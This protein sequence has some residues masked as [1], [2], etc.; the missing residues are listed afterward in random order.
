[1]VSAAY[2]P[3]DHE[4]VVY[5]P[6]ELPPPPEA[7]GSIE[8]QALSVE[9]PA[10]VD[11][12]EDLP[13]LLW[14]PTDN[15]AIVQ[16][17]HSS[18][19]HN[20]LEVVVSSAPDPLTSS[21]ES[22][23]EDAVTGEAEPDVP[24][25]VPLAFGAGPLARYDSGAGSTFVELPGD[26][27]ALPSNVVYPED[28][29]IAPVEQPVYIAVPNAVL[30]APIAE[31]EDV[32][33]NVVFD[34][35]QASP[36]LATLGFHRVQQAY[37]SWLVNMSHS[38]SLYQGI[39][40]HNY[41]MTH[42][43]PPGFRATVIYYEWPMGNLDRVGRRFVRILRQTMTAYQQVRASPYCD[44]SWNVLRVRIYCYQTYY[45]SSFF[46]EKL[47]RCTTAFDRL[48]TVMDEIYEANVPMDL[49]LLRHD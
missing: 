43:Y 30:D 25:A 15:L 42:I 37:E 44:V 45:S 6:H 14:F 28:D 8:H 12:I 17:G 21:E 26:V 27:S 23:Y 4:E 49:R 39:P 18:S 47:T 20:F 29:G 24:E 36:L 9:I 2:L 40:S 22:I 13:S 31:P 19:N 16:N 34:P 32:E 35:L 10:F 5:T 41:M 33:E 3:V 38:I 7:G 46:Q 48:E 11:D 1:M